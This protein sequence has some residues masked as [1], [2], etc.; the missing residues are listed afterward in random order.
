MKL[1]ANKEY[2]VTIR[3]SLTEDLDEHTLD[4]ALADTLDEYGAE[5]SDI[6]IYK[7]N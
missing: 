5:F 7:E 3:F 2:E 1:E 4:T 6:G